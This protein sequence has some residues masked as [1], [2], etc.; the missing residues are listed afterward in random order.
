MELG[1]TV[2]LPRAPR[3]PICPIQRWCEGLRR[4]KPESYPAPRPRRATEAH[5]LAAAVIRRNGKILMVRGLEEGLLDDLWNFPAAF[6]KSSAQALA[7]LREKLKDIAPGQARLRKPFAEVRHGITYRSI[8]VE[9]YRAAVWPG[10]G[11]RLSR[12]FPLAGLPR[13]AVSQL[14]RKIAARLV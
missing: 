1:Q 5:H 8:R 12:W 7:G 2:C 9:I 13:A 4:G 3:C 11:P 10:A 14:A 6:G